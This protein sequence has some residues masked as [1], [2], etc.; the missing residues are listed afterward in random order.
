MSITVVS[1]NPIRRTS[2]RLIPIRVSVGP[3]A[4]AAA[5]MAALAPQAAYAQGGCGR[6]DCSTAVIEVSAIDV[7][8]YD[9]IDETEVVP[10]EPNTG[11]N[12]TITAYWNQLG[13]DPIWCDCDAV[14]N[15]VV[16]VAVDWSDSTGWSATC[17]GCN[18]FTGPVRGVAICS[19]YGCGSG[20]SIDN[21]WGYELVVSLDESHGSNCGFG[22]PSFLNRVVYATTSVDDGNQ[23]NTLYCSESTAVSPISQAFGTTDSGPFECTFSCGA[24]SGPQVDIVYD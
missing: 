6:N 20:M 7:I 19:T 9:Q 21:S 16:Y 22:Y 12:W 10:V 17:T 1:P 5:V 14:S 23:I 18:A 4:V 8:H 15:A 24:A 13:S 3:A 2:R 11:E